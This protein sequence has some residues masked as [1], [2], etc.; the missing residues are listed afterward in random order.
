MPLHEHLLELRRRL[1]RSSIAL[2]LGTI[3][4]FAF[5]KPILRFL[6]QPVQEFLTSPAG[7]LI[8]TE[9]GEYIGT[10]MKVSLLAGLVLALP[11]VLYEAV[12]F[13]APGLTPKERRYLYILVPTS[14]LAFVVGAAFGYWV[15]LPPAFKVLLTFGSDVA[16]PMI[17]IG[18][19]VGLMLQLL[20]WMGLSFEL[21][22]VIFLLA[23]IGVVNTR[24]LSRFRPYAIVLAFVLSAIITPTVD[25]VNQTLVA[26]PL[27]VLYE[28]S[29]WLSRLAAPRRR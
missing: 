14:L 17:R 7:Q 23:K 29:I 6:V 18:P 20:L 13:V 27:V 1:V 24:L 15:L 28:I 22:V 16:T 8:F 3:V 4:A 12:M 25:P 11:V 5:H 26:V 19:L 2:V 9:P 21:P 10:A